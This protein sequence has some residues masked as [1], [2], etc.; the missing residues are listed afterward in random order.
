MSRTNIKTWK[1]VHHGTVCLRKGRTGFYLVVVG[2]E[3]RYKAIPV[4]FDQ[5]IWNEDEAISEAMNLISLWEAA[6]KQTHTSN[7]EVIINNQT[8]RKE[9]NMENNKKV[10]I[11][12]DRKIGE[13]GSLTALQV[14]P[15]SGDDLA[16]PSLIGRLVRQGSLGQ[17]KFAWLIEGS[18]PLSVRV[19]QTRQDG[20][21]GSGWKQVIDRPLPDKVKISHEPNDEILYLV[22]HRIV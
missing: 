8:N 14:I 16:F 6:Y 5:N 21:L 10:W 11:L 3:S 7:N 17:A 15:A 9:V 4:F 18:S 12:T 13:N 19:R 22:S 1:T 2:S 20:S